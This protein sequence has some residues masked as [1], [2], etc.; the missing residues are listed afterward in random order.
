M[1]GAGNQFLAGA[2]LP[3]DQNAGVGWSHL[4]Y[5]RK[6]CLQGRR[7][8]D[9]FLEHGRR[10]DFV[11]QRNVLV[12]ESLLR[13]LAI[14]DIGG[15]RIPTRRASLFIQPRFEA[16]EKPATLPVFTSQPHFSLE[17]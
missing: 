2:G 17:R 16:D 15:G 10:V 6:H 12:V 4:R 1:N 5:A 3:G 14:I 11:A 8:S 13:L 7:R 9:N